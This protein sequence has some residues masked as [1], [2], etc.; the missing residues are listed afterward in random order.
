[1]NFQCAAFVLLKAVIPDIQAQKEIR[2]NL[3]GIR[4]YVYIFVYINDCLRISLPNVLEWA[5]LFGIFN[6]PIYLNDRL[7]SGSIGL[8]QR[9]PSGQAV[10]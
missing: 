8:P 5:F 10:G 7:N 9:A 4:S 3:I 1:M 2:P 6:L